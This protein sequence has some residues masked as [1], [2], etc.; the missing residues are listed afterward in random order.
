M[1][2]VSSRTCSLHPS[3][4]WPCRFSLPH[5]SWV[6]PWDLLSVDFWV[7]QR[8]GAGLKASWQSLPGPV[9]CNFQ[10]NSSR[11]CC[12]MSHQTCLFSAP[13]TCL[14]IPNPS[15]KSNADSEITKSG[16]SVPSLSPK[17][18]HLFSSKTAQQ[19]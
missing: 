13:K 1:P 6:P 18:M 8:A 19:P 14:A 15:R 3:V 4:G 11:S 17:R 12:L 16:S 10:G 5:R 9:S 2:A 7:K